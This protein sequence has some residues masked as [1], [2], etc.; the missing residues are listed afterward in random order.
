MVGL[1]RSGCGNRKDIVGPA[2]SAPRVAIAPYR[3]V[4]CWVPRPF[5]H[6]RGGPH[7]GADKRTPNGGSQRSPFP[8]LSYRH[9]S[10]NRFRTSVTPAQTC[11]RAAQPG[12]AFAR[13]TWVASEF[14]HIVVGH[15][16]PPNR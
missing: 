2:S 7:V 8:K 4:R 12:D 9:A 15:G 14:H 10:G 11:P 13:P 6:L 1:L 5:P 16:Y 3:T